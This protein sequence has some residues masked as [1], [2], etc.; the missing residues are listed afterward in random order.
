MVWERSFDFDNV[1]TSG[2]FIHRLLPLYSICQ[3]S[4]VFALREGKKR[5]KG[6]SS[7]L[8]KFHF[9]NSSSFLGHVCEFLSIVI[10]VRIF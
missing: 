2:I 7:I 8:S 10:E 4:N 1:L 3:L 5:L 6:K 9:S